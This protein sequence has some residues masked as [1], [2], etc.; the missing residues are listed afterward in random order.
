MVDVVV[1]DE[2]PAAFMKKRTTQFLRL[3]RNNEVI[4]EGNIKLLN[5]LWGSIVYFLLSFYFFIVL[6]LFVNCLCPV[7]VATTLSR[8]GSCF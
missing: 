2:K 6:Y 8:N 4:P 3:D 1:A 7:Y 5:A